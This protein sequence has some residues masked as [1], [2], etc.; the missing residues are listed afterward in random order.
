MVRESKFEQDFKKELD[1]RLPGGFY[2][3]GNSAL[4]QGI[5]D[6]LFFMKD[7]GRL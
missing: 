7:I 5:P 2:I 3:K 6:R 4:R 1:K